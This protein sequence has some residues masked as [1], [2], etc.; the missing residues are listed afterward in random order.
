VKGYRRYIFML[1][2]PTIL[3]TPLRSQYY[4]CNSMYI[5]ISITTFSRQTADRT[6]PQRTLGGE[7]KEKKM[8]PPEVVCLFIF[9]FIIGI[10]IHSG[11]YVYYYTR[12]VYYTRIRFIAYTYI[13][14]YLYWYA[15]GR[16]PT[17]VFIII[18]YILCRPPPPPPARPPSV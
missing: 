1:R 3:V 15:T 16:S 13:I 9:L 8:F 10:P 14:H 6:M 5:I 18:L 4:T 11:I 12:Y 2:A 17:L 7:L